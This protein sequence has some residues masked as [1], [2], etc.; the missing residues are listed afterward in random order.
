MLLNA[1]TSTYKLTE[2]IVT[3]VLWH[4]N[5]GP[6]P[7]RNTTRWSNAGPELGQRLTNMS[8]LPAN[9]IWPRMADESSAAMPS[10][11]ILS[12]DFCQHTA[13]AL[14][15]P[16]WRS[17]KGGKHTS[18]FVF[19]LLINLATA[20]TMTDYLADTNR[21]F[22]CWRHYLLMSYAAENNAIFRFLILPLSIEVKMLSFINVFPR[23]ISAASKCEMK[24]IGL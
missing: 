12:E 23:Q 2:K 19:F 24:W 7:A 5:A 18:T 17:K 20:P 21:H 13:L 8:C 9:W 16:V 1:V 3:A 4:A 6:T 14:L 15:S 10:W 11:L 22:K